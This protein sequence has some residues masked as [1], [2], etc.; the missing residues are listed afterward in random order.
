MINWIVLYAGLLEVC[1]FFGMRPYLMLVI[2]RYRGR[3]YRGRMSQHGIRSLTRD[4]RD[5]GSMAAKYRRLAAE[6]SRNRRAS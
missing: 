3:M 2:L 5:L 1:L 4:V 6:L